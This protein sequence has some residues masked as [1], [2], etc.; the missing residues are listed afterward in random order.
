MDS[1]KASSNRFF[2]DVFIGICFVWQSFAL[3][4]DK[5]QTAQLFVNASKAAGRPI[6]ETLFGIFFE[7]CS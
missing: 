5:N 3:E 4:V 1:H 2:I 6:P 7:V